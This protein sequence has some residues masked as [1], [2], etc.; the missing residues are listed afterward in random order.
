M[1]AGFAIFVPPSFTQK[2]IEIGLNNHLQ[3]TFVGHVERGRKQVIIRP[4]N[5]IYKEESLGVR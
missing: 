4:K 2:S 3:S 1:G 5:L